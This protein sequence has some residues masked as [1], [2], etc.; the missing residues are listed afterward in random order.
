MKK[1]LYSLVEL[2]LIILILSSL[3]LLFT[4]NSEEEKNNNFKKNKILLASIKK[5][6]LGDV[7]NISKVKNYFD[8]IGKLPT[9]LQDLFIKP[10]DIPEY[11]QDLFTGVFYGW[12]GPYLS[13]QEVSSSLIKKAL[14]D[15]RLYDYSGS[16]LSTAQKTEL[17]EKIKNIRVFFDAFEEQYIPEE[18][19]SGD[20]IS[21]RKRLNLLYYS[22]LDFDTDGVSSTGDGNFGW[23]YRLDLDDTNTD[24]DESKNLIIR[25]KGLDKE[26]DTVSSNTT[27]NYRKD[28][29]FRPL[30]TI[31]EYNYTANPYL[32]SEVKFTNKTNEDYRTD[33]LRIGF[34]YP[35][36]DLDANW[37]DNAEFLFENRVHL[38]V[39]KPGETV[40]IKLP[41]FFARAIKKYLPLVPKIAV[42]VFSPMKKL[43]DYIF[44]SL[45]SGTTNTSSFRSKINYSINPII[46]ENLTAKS[47]LPTKFHFE[48]QP[49]ITNYISTKD[50]FELPI[51]VGTGG[52]TT[53][54]S[55]EIKF[56]FSHLASTRYAYSYI[57]NIWGDK[58]KIDSSSSIGLYDIKSV[59]STNFYKLNIPTN[60]KKIF[61]WQEIIPK[62]FQLAGEFAVQR[63]GD[64]I[65]TAYTAVKN[66]ATF[67]DFIYSKSFADIV[68]YYLNYKNKPVNFDL[69]R[70]QTA[71][72]KVWF[73]VDGFINNYSISISIFRI[74]ALPPFARNPFAGLPA[75]SA[76]ASP[77]YKVFPTLRSSSLKITS[78][79]FGR[80]MLG[81]NAFH[82]TKIRVFAVL[83]E[84][85]TTRVLLGD[86][87]DIDNEE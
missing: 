67:I 30:I 20:Y 10:D 17:E 12:R 66:K 33:E 73:P 76:N 75:N 21:G 65:L 8:D 16:T 72:S 79:T 45:E 39:I 60:A 11:K 29:P 77:N 70:D 49:A 26:E 78:G 55:P 59:N 62:Y 87:L 80:V 52:T 42:V 6:I 46:I 84:G 43:D 36:I 18:D 37:D 22:P 53:V 82:L 3:T 28:F 40:T 25:T 51:Q 61:I 2:T 4:D 48:I 41:F 34:Y 63:E 85:G 50:T 31:N 27:D 9:R 47:H 74:V 38:D 35:G 1:R 81:P 68:V 5:A 13:S 14:D 71:W 69:L 23:I 58:E 57:K 54:V 56:T 24:I 64:P 83:I 86:I 7:K 44:R 19:N 15:T 32:V